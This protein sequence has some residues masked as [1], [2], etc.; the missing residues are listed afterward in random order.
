VWVTRCDGCGCGEQGHKKQKTS[1]SAA[2]AEAGSF[3]VVE[4][5]VVDGDEGW[6]TE[7]PTGCPFPRSSGGNQPQQLQQL[8]QPQAGQ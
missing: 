5:V 3:T 8:Q 7:L 1:E 2:S 6:S 4:T